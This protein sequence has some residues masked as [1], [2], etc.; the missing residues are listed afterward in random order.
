[1]ALAALIVALVSAAVGLFDDDRTRAPAAARDDVVAAGDPVGDQGW[2]HSGCRFSQRSMDDPIVFPAGSG[3]AHSHG[4]AGASHSHDF[5]GSRGTES[6]STNASLR[7]DPR[8]TCLRDDEEKNPGLALVDRSAYWTPT[9]L[10]DGHP[11]AP[12]DGVTAGYNV[13]PRDP[14]RIRPFPKDLKMIAGSASG[15]KP[16][17]GEAVVYR[18]RCG[19][20]PV[21]AP[22]SRTTAPTCATPDLR[23]DI[24]FPDCSNG[25]TDS[26]DHKS[27]MA[28]SQPA[29]D[30][31]G[32]WVC[33]STHPIYVPQLNLKYRFATTGGP[34]VSFA[35]G[36]MSTAHADFMNGW[37]EERLA[38]LVRACLNADEYCGGTNHP[39]PGH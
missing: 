20:G 1:V 15:S 19:S 26:A 10:V 23:V 29:A 18:V 34:A 11:L 7:A 39:V 32:Q 27:H 21:V 5:I 35:T 16:L 14:A 2:F 37:D 38:H 25:R 24:N 6:A 8:S 4:H 22:G 9:L 31:S 17:L 36:D 3:A 12:E 13:G 30:G 28:Y 33:P